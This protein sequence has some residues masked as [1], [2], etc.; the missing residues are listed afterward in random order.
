MANGGAG[1]KDSECGHVYEHGDHVAV[2][3]E[4]AGEENARDVLLSRL[5]VASIKCGT[6]EVIPSLLACMRAGSRAALK[7]VTPN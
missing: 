6:E 3:P 5:L 2:G 1:G 7:A 4:L